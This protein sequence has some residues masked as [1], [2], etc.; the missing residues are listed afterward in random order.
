MFQFHGFALS[1]GAVPISSYIGTW[2]FAV[3]L[4]DKLLSNIRI[5]N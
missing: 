1:S 5:L 3:D 4:A 2:S